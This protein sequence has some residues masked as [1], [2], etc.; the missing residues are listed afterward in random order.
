MH[1]YCKCC[2]L[3][4]RDLCFGLVARPEERTEYVCVCVCVSVCVREREREREYES[5]ASTM[6]RPWPAVGCCVMGGKK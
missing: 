2:V 5:D 4:G 3:S 1:V 6:R